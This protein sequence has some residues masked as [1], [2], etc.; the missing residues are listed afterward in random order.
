MS[1]VNLK[2][3]IK[4]FF[5]KC[6]LYKHTS[7]SHSHHKTVYLQDIIKSNEFLNTKAKLPIVLGKDLSG[8]PVILDIARMPH[9]LIAGKS[10][11]GKSMAVNT[12]ILSLLYKFSPEQVHFIMIDPKIVELSIYD[13]IPHLLT[14]VITEMKKAGNTLHWV[15]NEMERRYILLDRLNVRNIEEYSDKLKQ[16]GMG[17][18]LSY[19]VIIIDEFS[20]L[21]MVHG[22]RIEDYIVQIG[23]K[24]QAV[25]I[26]LI[27]TTQRPSEEVITK[28]IKSNIASRIA[29]KVTSNIDSKTI[30]DKNGAESLLEQGDM[31]Y[32][33]A[34]TPNLMHIQGAFIKDSDIKK[35]A[36]DWRAKSRPN[37]IDTIIETAKNDEKSGS[38]NN[39]DL[40][41]LFDE[42][43][44]FVIESEVTSASGL[45][46]QFSISFPRAVRIL[47]QLQQKGILSTPDNRG[48]R[49]ILT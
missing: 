19:I 33:T 22:K 9:L 30:L 42:V 44:A 4:A 6:T 1:N 5:S 31:L 25:G 40:D 47:D 3:R 32:S 38:S 12:M 16:S 43:V 39:G 2:N 41:P 48:K 20:D 17:E 46:R 36:D 37:Y 35:V 34:G 24:A 26:H 13:N 23:Q 28:L 49:T 29:F 18:N 45:Q 10:G 8:Q 21:L 27:L 14:P 15:I 7:T 11:S